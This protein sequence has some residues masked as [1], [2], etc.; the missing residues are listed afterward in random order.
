MKTQ[1]LSPA[2]NVKTDMGHA[3]VLF[4]NTTINNIPCSLGGLGF[5]NHDRRP[6]PGPFPCEDPI[7]RF[8]ISPLLLFAVAFYVYPR[9]DNETAIVT[10]HSARVLPSSLYRHG[11]QFAD[12]HRKPEL[13]EPDRERG[14]TWNTITDAAN[15]SGR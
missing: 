15:D 4:I 7:F 1:Q 13:S 12:F 14:I 8:D 3:L 2:G 5:F 10:A 6:G 11:A 9:V